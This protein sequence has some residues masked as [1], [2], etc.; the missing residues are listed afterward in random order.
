[1]VGAGRRGTRGGEG[2]RRAGARRKS[3]PDGAR[4]NHTGGHTAVA[5]GG[6]CTRPYLEAPLSRCGGSGWLSQ[7]WVQGPEGW[8]QLRVGGMDDLHGA[9]W[10]A[11]G[12][13]CF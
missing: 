7:M 11:W 10:E 9:V 1:M 13:A 8:C 12:L 3:Y 4:N 2:D 5:E 6:G